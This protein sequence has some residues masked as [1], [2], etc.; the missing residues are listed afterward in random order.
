M[1]IFAVLLSTACSNMGRLDIAASARDVTI[2]D[3]KQTDAHPNFLAGSCAQTL[4]WDADPQ[5]RA[6]WVQAFVEAP[7]TLTLGSRPVGV[8]VSAKASSR[9][10][11]NGHLLGTNGEPALNKKD[12][13]VGRMDAVFFAPPGTLREGENEI[14]VL[15]S[16]HHGFLRFGFPVHR[17]GIGE[18]KDP[19]RSILIAYWPSL[20]PLGALIVGA[21]YFFV[22]AFSGISRMNAAFLVLVCLFAAA[23]L[24][25]EVYRGLAPYAYTA[26]EWRMVL[27]VAFSMGFGL[28]LVAYTANRF[29]ESRR[30]AFIGLGWL[31]VFISAASIVSYDAKAGVSILIAVGAS[32]AIALYAGRKG[33]RQAYLHAAAF[34]AFAIALIAFPSSFLDVLFFYEIAALLIVLFVGQAMAF[35]KERRELESERARAGQLRAALERATRKPD[36]EELRIASAGKVEIVSTS[37]IALMRSADD[38]V[39]IVMDDDKKY[40]HNSSLA[41]MERDLPAAF[42]RVHRS[43]LVNTDMISSLEREKSGVGRLYLK[44]GAQAPVSRRIMPRVRD[45][46]K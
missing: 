7:E 6:I 42:L 1:M 13:L 14:V 43:Y 40:L 36:G 22:M 16:S 39:E 30:I 33:K 32:A 28:C 41:Q 2:C 25:T 9:V 11:L 24:V 20:P 46:I 37:K 27:I 10:Y 19:T 44:N 38:Y 3:A 21:L 18:Y 26:H 17:I 31:A 4:F 29:L 34:M 5:G 35:A 15:M 12:E 8:Y 45:A 23:Q